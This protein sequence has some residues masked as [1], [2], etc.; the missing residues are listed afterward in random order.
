MVR[1]FFMG[2]A[3]V[4]VFAII[5][6]YVNSLKPVR[7]ARAG[8]TNES[9]AAISKAAFRRTGR[10]VLPVVFITLIEWLACQFGAFS[11][12]KSVDS[13]WLRDSSPSPSKSFA[14][15]FYDLWTNLV[16]TWTRGSNAYDPVQ[17]TM[18]YL[19][20]GSM[21]VYLTLV[22]SAFAKPKW[23]LCIF[24]VAYVYNWCLGD[25]R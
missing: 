22:L 23:R 3:S 8:Q 11:L 19:L 1:D 6:G 21:F 14:G 2:R 5:S 24:G 7:Q 9:L 4:A 13:Q 16:S 18:A 25:G 17:W 15:A 20:K 12:A 10:F